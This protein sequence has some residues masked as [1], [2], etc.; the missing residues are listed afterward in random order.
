M[1]PILNLFLDED[2]CLRNHRDNQMFVL[3][4]F[5]STA[6]SIRKAA[7]WYLQCFT[8]ILWHALV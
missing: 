1:P 2:L 6:Y 7:V 3:V 4:T 5:V 8:Y